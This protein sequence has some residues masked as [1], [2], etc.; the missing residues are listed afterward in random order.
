MAIRILYLTGQ[1][2]LPIHNV[3]RL[4]TLS[5]HTLNTPSDFLAEFLKAPFFLR[6]DL[7][8]P[9]HGNDKDNDSRVILGTGNQAEIFCDDEQEVKDK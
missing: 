6:P 7:G 8:H 2:D 5:I 3:S 9:I 1:D 4:Q